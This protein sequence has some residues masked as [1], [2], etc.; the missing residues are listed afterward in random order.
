MRLGRI[1]NDYTAKGFDLVKKQNL[2]FLEFC[3]NSQ[4]EAEKLVAAVPAVQAECRRTSL[5]V[6]CVGRW[7]HNVQENGVLLP[8]R[9]KSYYDLLDAAAALGAKTFVAGCNYD[10][11]VSLYRN[12]QNAVALFGGLLEHAKGKNIAVAVQNCSW[13]NF[14]ATDRDFDIV[15]GELPDL[16]LKYDPSHAYNRGEDYLRLLAKWGSRVAHVHIKGTTHAGEFPVADPPAGMDDIRWG[17]LFSIL[18]SV[19]YDGDL[20][21]EP[22]SGAWTGEKGEA[23]V[24][25]TRDFISGLMV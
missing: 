21:I 24:A 5:P 25:F 22:H 3:C 12:Y 10:D 18:Y 8:E 11:S 6:S 4:E 14:V 19:G 1:Q 9:L 16:K 17:S 15:L 2:D 20:S 23:G 7:N 13:F